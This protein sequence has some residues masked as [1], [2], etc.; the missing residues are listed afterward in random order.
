MTWAKGRTT[1]CEEDHIYGLLGIFDVTMPLVYGE[2][3]SKRFP[4]VL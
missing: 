4:E 2:S 1:K 3:E